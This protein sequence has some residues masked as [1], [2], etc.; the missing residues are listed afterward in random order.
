MSAAQGVS[1][2]TLL[3]VTTQHI[4]AVTSGL[5]SWTVAEVVGLVDGGYRF[6]VEDRLGVRA[7]VEVVRPLW[8]LPYI[9]TH[10]DDTTSDNL[11]SLPG[12]PFYTGAQPRGLLD[13]YRTL[14]G[15]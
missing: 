5:R 15:S 8:H 14:L 12:G 7:Y 3:T 6:Y 11:L 4:E 2:F 13:P 10:R 9:R 1:I